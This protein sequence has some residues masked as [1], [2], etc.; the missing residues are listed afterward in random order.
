VSTTAD[1]HSGPVLPGGAGMPSETAT[2]RAV[3]QAEVAKAIVGHEEAVELTT[4]AAVV[5]GHVLLEGP[6]GVAKTLLANAVAHTLGISFNRMQFTPDTLPRHI[7]GETVMRLG[8]PVFLPGPVFTNLL[9]AD[10]INRAEPRTQAALLEA[11]EEHHVTVD[12]QTHWLPSPFIVLAT[13]NP[14]EQEG[15]HPLPESQ[16]DRFLFKVNMEYGSEQQEVDVV[17]LPHAGLAPDVVGEIQPLLSPALLVSAQRELDATHVSDDVAHYAVRIIRK[18]RE[19]PDVR[20]GAS[21]RAALHLVAA[22]KANARLDGRQEVE[23]RDVDRMVVPVLRHR[24]LMMKGTAEG[25][26]E[27]VLELVRRSD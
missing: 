11:M 20:L 23:R 8:E 24:L 12:G 14:Y 3:V 13:Q 2:L 1:A 15:V 26:V 22:A 16:L 19:L 27:A 7:A 21:P 5:G 4:L 6:P 17:R 25:A 18:T 10:E 9:L